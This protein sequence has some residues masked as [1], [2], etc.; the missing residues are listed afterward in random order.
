MLTMGVSTELLESILDGRKT[1]EGRL[2]SGK[3][4]TLRKGDKISLREDT[5]QNDRIISSAPDK[6]VIT[7]EQTVYYRNFTDML[8]SINFKAVIPQ[9][10]SIEAAQATYDRFYSPYQQAES[11]VVAIYF[12]L[13]A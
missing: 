10:E 2:R 8:Q 5:W 3:F 6:A 9:A 11:G 12:S 7:V 13:D 4:I 1:I